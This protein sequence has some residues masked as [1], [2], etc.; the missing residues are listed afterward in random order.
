MLIR[1][2]IPTDFAYWLPY[3]ND[4][5]YELNTPEWTSL[6][7]IG[8]SLNA[9]AEGASELAESLG[10]SG[11][12]KKINHQLTKIAKEGLKKFDRLYI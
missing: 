11:L 8:D 10:K 5:A 12:A 6:D 1:D 2:A 9:A 3:F 7:P 4:T